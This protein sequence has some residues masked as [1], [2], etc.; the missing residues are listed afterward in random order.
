MCFS[1]LQ[2]QNFTAE[3]LAVHVIMVFNDTNS[4]IDCSY[5]TTA[6][7]KCII[8]IISAKE[9][10]FLPDFVCLSVCVLAR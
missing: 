8:V 5:G 9:V 3:N 6:L 2:R 4:F 7:Y 1:A 10:M